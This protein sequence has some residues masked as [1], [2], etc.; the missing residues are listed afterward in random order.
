MISS[1]IVPSQ[2]FGVLLVTV[3][4]LFSARQDLRFPQKVLSGVFVAVPK[5]LYKNFLDEFCKPVLNGYEKAESDEKYYFKLAER[6][7]R[8]KGREAG[9]EAVRDACQQD[10]MEY[11]NEKEYD[12]DFGL[13]G[14]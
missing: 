10:Q 12:R 7:C 4:Q 3:A 9:E 6:A 13:D 1:G 8:L 14:W 11:E 2:F 5:K